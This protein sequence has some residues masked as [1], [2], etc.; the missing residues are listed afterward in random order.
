MRKFDYIFDYPEGFTSLP[1]YNAHRGKRISVLRRL[2]KDE[3]DYE[4]EGM[5]EIEAQDGWRG[6]AWRSELR[7]A[8]VAA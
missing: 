1:E 8:E 3:F 7:R 6:Q 4:G 5:Y 2:R